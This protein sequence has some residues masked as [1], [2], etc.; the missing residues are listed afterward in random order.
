MIHKTFAQ[1][2]A[3]NRRCAFLRFL[4]DDPDYAMNTSLLQSA[5]A[6]IGHGVSRDQI[7]TDA[8]WLEEQGLVAREDLDGIVVVK[9]TRRGADVA[10]G[11][12]V[13]PGV[14][15]PGPGM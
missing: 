12:A 2:Q 9:I 5:L 7:D 11:R 8:A 14:K 3:E 13:V 10:A 1:L 4:A 15:R 6:A